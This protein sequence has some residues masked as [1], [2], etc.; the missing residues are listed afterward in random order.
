MNK[1]NTNNKKNIETNINF[2]ADDRLS[3]DQT[4][5]IFIEKNLKYEGQSLCGLLSI[6]EN[7]R[8]IYHSQLFALMNSIENPDIIIK[9]IYIN[10]YELINESDIMEEKTYRELY[11]I[12]VKYY[13]FICKQPAINWFKTLFPLVSISIA[14]FKFE[15]F[16]FKNFYVGLVG[17]VINCS[18]NTVDSSEL[19]FYWYGDPKDWS[20]GY[21]LYINSKNELE[22]NKCKFIV[23]DEIRSGHYNREL[24]NRYDLAWRDYVYV[25][26]KKSDSSPIDE[27]DIDDEEYI[28]DGDYYSIRCMITPYVVENFKD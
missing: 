16:S 7:K 20:I 27:N 15:N 11:Y 8:F 25:L 6:R 12:Y 21:H 13:T 24:L 3:N 19:A 17:R 2:P 22:I 18:F 28:S 14:S 5:N 23:T 9:Y 1:K 4:K 26:Y 10:L